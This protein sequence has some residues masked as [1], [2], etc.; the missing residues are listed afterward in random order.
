[1]NYYK[2]ALLGLELKTLTYESE[3][4]LKPFSLVKVRLKSKLQIGVIISNV[5]KPDFKTSAIIEYMNSHFT[6]FQIELAKFISYYYT[7]KIG[8]SLDL[9][10]A[11]NDD[12]PDEKNQES[13]EFTKSPILS[14]KQNEALAFVNEN[15]ISLL[16]GDTG[17][18]KSEIYIEKI[19]S[20]LNQNKQAL[21]LMPE[22]SLTPQ[23]EKRLKDYFGDTLGIWHSK[24]TKKKKVQILEKFQNGQI[25]LIAGARSALFL[26]FTN[27]ALI[28]VDE[29]H[30]D[31]YKSSSNPYY[32]ARD[33]AIFA[34]NKFKIPVILGSA[35]PSVASFYK[36]KHFR[37]KGTF[38][39]SKKEY[40][41]DEDKI[42]LS[43]KII[44]EIRKS[45]EN[46]KQV[47]VFLPTRA[48][49]KLL[50]C[51]ECGWTFTCPN[52]SVN[53]SLHSKSNSMKCHYCGFSAR[54]PQSCPKCNNNDLEARKIGT[55]ELKNQLECIFPEA[56]I[57][58][59]DKDEITTQ[60]KLIK[61]LK[62]FN[63]GQIDILVGTQMLSKGH[64]YHNVDLAVI[65]GLDSH[66]NHCDFRARE[67][68]LAL[69]MQVAGRAGRS[70]EG[71]VL[72]QSLE[73][74]FFK[75]YI[76][77]YDKF[78]NE[79]LDFRKSLYPPFTRLLRIIISQK[80]EKLA[81]QKQN[82]LIEEFQKIDNLEIVGYGKAFI[83]FISSK[84]RYEILLRSTN[85]NSLL[86]AADIAKFFE[87]AA[88][89]D[90]INFN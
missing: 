15:Q 66:L 24:I 62:D 44:Y 87:A 38:F 1:M 51:Q 65:M 72:I 58:K 64:D 89:I 55:S 90:P 5:K 43:E 67:K 59:F 26:P 52:C 42:E 36:F 70:G 61:L 69:A 73:C 16:F 76:N 37:L 41:F 30:D 86:K 75:E 23:M 56:K 13:L 48:N 31:S 46:K 88:D 10:E 14:E 21:F 4:V 53:L 7:S 20:I 57:A 40:I 9:F 68:T 54:I 33:L 39:E 49:F 32:N 83:E 35:T 29:E 19:R 60:R 22:I 8:M 79:E 3:L 2:I 82:R 63:L 85:H 12:L 6:H 18:G 11:F 47:V 84:Y 17:S 25:R 71:R 45:L 50:R 78:L 28:V 34:G 77:D 80:D 74:D 27:L 81:I